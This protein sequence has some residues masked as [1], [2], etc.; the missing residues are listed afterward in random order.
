MQ[1]NK[2]K[3]HFKRLIET[4]SNS[5]RIKISLVRAV[6]ALDSGRRVA[7]LV[8]DYLFKIP[9]CPK[10]EFEV[11]EALKGLIIAE[12]NRLY[13]SLDT[14][15]VEIRKLGGMTHGITKDDIR[16][17]FKGDMLDLVSMLK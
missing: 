9:H 15:C 11:R 2:I 12:G 16:Q 7:K 8:D 17:E 5:T 1:L 14:E 6:T 13:S 3:R 4:S 10:D